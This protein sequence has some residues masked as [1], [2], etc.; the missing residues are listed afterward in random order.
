MSEHKL[1]YEL[2]DRGYTVRAWYGATVGDHAAVEIRK[3]DEVIEAWGVQAHHI[4]NVA[5]HF[6]EIVDDLLAVRRPEGP[7]GPHGSEHD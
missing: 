2:S 7:I 4:W 3:G 6:G 5:A 1:A